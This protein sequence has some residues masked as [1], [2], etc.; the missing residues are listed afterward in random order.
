MSASMASTENFLSFLNEQLT[1]PHRW[2]DLMDKIRQNDENSWALMRAYLQTGN[3]GGLM[4]NIFIVAL[5]PALGEEFLFR[6]TIQRLFSEWFRNEHLAVWLAAVL[7][8]LM[9]YQFLGFVPRILL[10]ALFGY[11]FVWTGSI[12]MPVLAHFVNNGLAVV[13][14]FIFDRGSLKTE[15]ENIG[16]E[17]NAVLMIIASTV[18]TMLILAVIQQQRKELVHS[19][20]GGL[21]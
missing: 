15:P 19:G 18:L 7:F 17:Q 6:G 9:H 10:G 3:I 13:Y 16:L 20:S 12:W 11:L 4:V 8:S 21:K 2:S 1:L 14:Y 5:I